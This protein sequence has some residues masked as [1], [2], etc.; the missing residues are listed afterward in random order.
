MAGLVLKSNPG[1]DKKWLKV[2]FEEI[3]CYLSQQQQTSPPAKEWVLR[4]DYWVRSGNHLAKGKKVNDIIIIN[5][6][7][8][9]KLCGK[10]HSAEP[11]HVFFE[12]YL[13]FSDVKNALSRYN[14]SIAER[15]F[16]KENGE[17]TVTEPENWN[18]QAN[19]LY[20]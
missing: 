3:E 11:G 9:I 10:F 7:H 1:I 14:I 18:V 6:N 8:Q 17:V 5:N 13:T 2:Q 4:L 15:D 16:K 19:G 12:P 20:I